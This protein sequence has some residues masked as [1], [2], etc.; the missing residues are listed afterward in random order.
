LHPFTFIAMSEPLGDLTEDG[1]VNVSDVQC[2]ILVALWTLDANPGSTPTCVQG[3]PLEADVLCDGE[4]NVADIVT[5]IA[6]ALGAPLSEVT[7]ADADGCPDNC[8]PPTVRQGAPA[9]F[10]GV[11][12]GGPYR[13]RQAPQSPSSPGWSTGGGLALRARPLRA[14]EPPS[15]ALP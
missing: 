10:G 8:A 11:S 5:V 9:S 14:T 3:N 7:D 4:V 6:R 13:L 15:A 2:S 12:T 1:S